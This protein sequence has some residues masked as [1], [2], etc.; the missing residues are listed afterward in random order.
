MVA[1][2]GVGV[3]TLLLLTACCCVYTRTTSRDTVDLQVSSL[4]EEKVF[5]FS[6]SEDVG[7]TFLVVQRHTDGWGV[8]WWFSWWMASS[9]RKLYWV[10]RMAGKGLRMN[11]LGWVGVGGWVWLFVNTKRF[12]WSLVLPLVGTTNE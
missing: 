5:L 2:C 7:S 8:W 11:D 4:L 12:E 6:S 10:V 1:R 9:A 3:E